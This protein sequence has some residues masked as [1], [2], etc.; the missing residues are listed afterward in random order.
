MATP[1][2]PP[3]KGDPLPDAAWYARQH[4]Y[5]QSVQ[6]D[7]S[8]GGELEVEQVG[9]KT[10]LHFA[11]YNCHKLAITTEEI[12]AAADADT[13]SSGTATLRPFNGIEKADGAEIDVWN[14]ADVAIETGSKVVVAL[15][16]GYWFIIAQYCE[17]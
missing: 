5:L 16:D 4:E 3:K 13:P 1:P 10:V 9:G 11:R 6:L 17:S 2:P 15:I 8:D 14:D 12:P 7:V